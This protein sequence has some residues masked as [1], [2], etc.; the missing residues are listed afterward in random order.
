MLRGHGPS[1]R[2]SYRFDVTLLSVLVM[3]PARKASVPTI[4]TVMT[5]R[6]KISLA[7]SLPMSFPGVSGYHRDVML[8]RA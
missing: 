5:A 3:A 7:T 4:A 6:T 1:R 8:A 2:S